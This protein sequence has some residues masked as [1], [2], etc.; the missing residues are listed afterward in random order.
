MA[1]IASKTIT[2]AE[3]SA[4]GGTAV[5]TDAVTLEGNFN[6][7]I[8]TA[9]TFTSAST[10]FVQRSV[11]STTWHDVDSFTALI[12]TFGFDPEIMYYRIGVKANGLNTGEQ[13]TVR[14]G[15]E[16]KAK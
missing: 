1:T 3:T 8:S 7:S 2:E 5:W 4:G 15:R 6:V 16:D 11:D 12:E 13:V 9:G 10:V 14:L